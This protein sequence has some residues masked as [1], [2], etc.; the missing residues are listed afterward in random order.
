MCFIIVLHTVFFCLQDCY[1][2]SWGQKKKNIG[3]EPEKKD[4]DL[5]S[6]RKTSDEYRDKVEEEYQLEADTNAEES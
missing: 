2:Q 6:E 5:D 3:E 4:S 1:V